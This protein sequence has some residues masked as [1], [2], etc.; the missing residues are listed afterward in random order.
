M[1]KGG[2]ERNKTNGL[3]LADRQGC[4]EQ[5]QRRV[6]ECDHSLQFICANT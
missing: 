1:K 4:R 6:L 5:R 2:H 3:G